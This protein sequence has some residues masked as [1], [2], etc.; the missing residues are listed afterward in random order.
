MWIFFVP[1]GRNR[2][3]AWWQVR[4]AYPLD[5]GYPRNEQERA[6][7]EHHQRSRR[8]AEYQFLD[9]RWMRWTRASQAAAQ[10]KRKAAMARIDASER[11]Q[12]EALAEQERAA[13]LARRQ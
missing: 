9:R 1:W 8:A 7:L 2:S 10:A 6:I 5:A 11:E 4:A 12:L 13:A 3:K